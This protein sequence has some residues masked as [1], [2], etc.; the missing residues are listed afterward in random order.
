M[1]RRTGAVLYLVRH[2]IAEARGPRWPDDDRRPL[3]REGARR[4]RRAVRGL[5]AL[6]LDVDRVAT[7]PLVR[8]RATADLLSRGLPAHP[9]ILTLPA[10]APGGTP[11]RTVRAIADASDAGA[12]ALVGHEPDLGML[13]AWLVGAVTPLALR[14]GGVCRIDLEG[15][16]P[17]RNGRLI[18]LATPR[19][20]R[21]M[22]RDDS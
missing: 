21:A 19:M 14:K 8:A 22:A 13:G 6:G 9:G 1:V 11:A 5:R 3:T 2:A 4:M 16:P 10:L 18:W 7:S 17:E 20:L 12:L 15:W